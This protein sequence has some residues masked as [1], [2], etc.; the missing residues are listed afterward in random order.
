VARVL[1]FKRLPL[2]ARL[3]AAAAGRCPRCGHGRIFRGRLAMHP[4]CPSCGLRFEREPGYF[5]GAM[6]VSYVLALPVMAVCIAAVYL[7]APQLSFEA[8]VALAALCFL[9]FVPMLFRYSRILWIHLDQT[10]DPSE[11]P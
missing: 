9:P 1:R 8:T 5:T 2:R 4:A 3:A 7:I 6:Y 10:V 11:E